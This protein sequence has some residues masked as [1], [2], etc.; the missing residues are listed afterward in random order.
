MGVGLVGLVDGL[1]GVRRGVGPGG[2]G[3]ELVGGTGQ[4]G[5]A[6]RHTHSHLTVHLHRHR[7]EKRGERGVRERGGGGLCD[8]SLPGVRWSWWPSR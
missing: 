7:Q 8:G 4:E 1:G 3:E 6:R 5:Q 2:D